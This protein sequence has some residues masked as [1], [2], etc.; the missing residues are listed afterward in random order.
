[1]YIDFPFLL[2]Y[3]SL[4]GLLLVHDLRTGLLPDKF[5][6][7]LLWS[8]LLFHQCCNPTQLSDALWGA[9]AGYGVFSLFYWGYRLAWHQE[10]LGYGDVKFLAALGA[11]HRW[12]SL[13]LLILL[14]AGLACCMAGVAFITHGKRK[15]KNP[16]PF[17]PYLAAAGFVVGWLNLIQGG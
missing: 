8:G 10:G 5:T 14:A 15:L 3:V 16:L 2:I 6:C 1:M 9:I 7:P 11:W 17:G 12:D 13:P 4:S